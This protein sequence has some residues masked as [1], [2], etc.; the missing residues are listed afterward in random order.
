M[1]RVGPP[2]HAYVAPRHPRVQFG[3]REP[4]VSAPLV[5]AAVPRSRWRP[6]KQRARRSGQRPVEY[7]FDGGHGILPT[8]GHWISPVAAMRSP[9]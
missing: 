9:H 3:A 6:V 8:G 1:G 2:G 7:R 4:R 5:L